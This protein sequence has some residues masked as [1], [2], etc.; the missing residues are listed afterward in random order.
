MDNSF[1]AHKNAQILTPK[2]NLNQK[3]PENGGYP[4]LFKN[5]RSAKC[6]PCVILHYEP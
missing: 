6:Y 3:L 4:L 2:L 1:S 5:L